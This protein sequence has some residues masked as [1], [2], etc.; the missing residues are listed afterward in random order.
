MT[1]MFK[2]IVC[3][4]GLLLLNNN[5]YAQRKDQRMEKQQRKYYK[6]FLVMHTEISREKMAVLG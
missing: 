5:T 2:A 1:I 4:A 3:L 6:A